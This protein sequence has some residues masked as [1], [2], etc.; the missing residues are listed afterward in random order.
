M[1]NPYRVGGRYVSK[2]T[3]ESANATVGAINRGSMMLEH[4]ALSQAG[5]GLWDVLETVIVTTK[6]LELTQ[7]QRDKA[8]IQMFKNLFIQITSL[9]MSFSIY[10]AAS[11]MVDIPF[12][13]PLIASFVSAAGS[14]GISAVGEGFSGLFI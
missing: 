10:R 5:S 13:G 7:E 8:Y 12:V 1:P 11:A 2:A 3:W 14:A 6:N 9:A 4:Q